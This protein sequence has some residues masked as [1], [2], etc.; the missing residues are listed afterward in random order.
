[1]TRNSSCYDIMRIWNHHK[2]REA[3][4]NHSVGILTFPN[5]TYYMS[6]NENKTVTLQK[7][8]EFEI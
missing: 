1:M 5:S 8:I 3:G 4:P 7:K 6:R 2:C